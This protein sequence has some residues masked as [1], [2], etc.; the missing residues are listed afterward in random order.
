MIVT[1]DYKQVMKIWDVR[2]QSCIQTVKFHFKSA[3]NSILYLENLGFVCLITSR[4]NLYPFEVSPRGQI[5]KSVYAVS[6]AYDQWNRRFVVATS[7][8]VR[9]VSLLTG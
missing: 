4:L 9:M 6:A 7:R 3:I 8:D 5:G 2:S 1:A